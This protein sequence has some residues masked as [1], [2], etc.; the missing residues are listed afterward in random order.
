MEIFVQLSGE[1]FTSATIARQDQLSRELKQ[2]EEDEEKLKHEITFFNKAII[3]QVFHKQ[4]SEHFIRSMCRSRLDEMQEE[5]H[6]KV[7][8]NILLK[9]V[10]SIETNRTFTC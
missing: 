6:E 7:F 1:D 3:T 4:D 8:V 9:L 10:V 2:S 5:L